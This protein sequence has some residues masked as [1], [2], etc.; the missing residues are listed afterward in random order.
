VWWIGRL[1]G[2][3]VAGGDAAMDE[4]RVTLEAAHWLASIREPDQYLAL[5]AGVA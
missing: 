3:E 5:F 1:L 2:A 4:A